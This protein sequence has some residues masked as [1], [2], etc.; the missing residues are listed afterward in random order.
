VKNVYVYYTYVVMPV[1]SV[2]ITVSSLQC[3]SSTLPWDCILDIST[4]CHV[5]AVP[6]TPTFNQ[7]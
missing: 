6:R 1:V 7:V 3:T 4:F 2:D 5:V